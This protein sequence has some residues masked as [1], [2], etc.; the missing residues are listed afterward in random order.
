MGWYP[1]HVWQVKG[2][3]QSALCMYMQ[4]LGLSRTVGI[5]AIYAIVGIN[6]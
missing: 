2:F 4:T 5:Y 3:D 1:S 6:A